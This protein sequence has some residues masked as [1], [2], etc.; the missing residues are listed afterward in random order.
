M[1]TLQAENPQLHSGV[2]S[3]S[4]PEV[5][6]A[7]QPLLLLPS[8]PAPTSRDPR[9]LLSPPWGPTPSG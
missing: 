2:S 6:Q 5:P 1:A 4:T 9:L 3:P 8:I 7:L